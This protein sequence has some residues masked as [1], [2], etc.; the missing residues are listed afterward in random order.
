MSPIALQTSLH[1]S[2]L[3]MNGSYLSSMGFKSIKVGLAIHGSEL[4]DID[5]VPKDLLKL[6]D[7][8]NVCLI[9]LKFI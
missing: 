5:L 4:Q 2:K 7:T 6:N 1:L 9:S 8:I 3:I